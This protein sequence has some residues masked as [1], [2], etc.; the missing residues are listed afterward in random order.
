MKQRGGEGVFLEF[1]DTVYHGRGSSISGDA[2]RDLLLRGDVPLRE[3][4]ATRL[5]IN[6]GRDTTAI[7]IAQILEVRSPSPR[8]Q[9][10]IGLGVGGALDAFVI[11][12]AA[13]G[14]W[15]CG[16]FY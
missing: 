12:W 6:R 1:V 10:W 7:P 13:T 15:N 8:N 2:L 4:P 9:K 16:P 14:G 5:L 11:Y 3:P